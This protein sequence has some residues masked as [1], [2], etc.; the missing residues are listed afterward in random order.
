MGDNFAYLTE[1]KQKCF[2]FQNKITFSFW[3][4]TFWLFDIFFSR[5]AFSMRLLCRSERP[6]PKLA[7]H[8]PRSMWEVPAGGWSL[9]PCCAVNSKLGLP[10][11]STSFGLLSVSLTPPPSARLL[12][13]TML[14]ARTVACGLGN[15]LAASFHVSKPTL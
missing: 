2:P 3:C 7:R 8:L 1:L 14:D 15:P 6:L 12:D 10:P 9:A 4:K 11:H 13:R 5:Y